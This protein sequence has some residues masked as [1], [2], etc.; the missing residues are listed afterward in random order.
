MDG[1]HHEPPQVDEGAN[2]R[3]KR[4]SRTLARARQG[5]SSA[6]GRLLQDCRG[7]LLAVAG[8]RLPQAIHSKQAASDLV[9]ESLTAATIHFGQFAGSNEADLLA[10]LCRI[11]DREITRSQRRFLD[12][13]KRDVRR[14][15]RLA[16]DS[17]G[18][19]AADLP[20]N[21]TPPGQRVER[22]EESQRLAAA[23]ALLTEEYRRVVV[24]RNFERRGF[25]QIGEQLGRSANAARKLWLRAL[26][27]LEQHLPKDFGHDSEL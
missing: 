23:M 13:D 3:A 25:N 5:S 12:A 14:E 16:H 7:Y 10:W 6:L 4:F 26:A 27:E 8:G 15:V 24:L 21:D 1:A 22:D 19:P 2:A 18:A 17:S 20:A 11:L 9:Q